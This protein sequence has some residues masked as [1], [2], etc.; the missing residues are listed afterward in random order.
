MATEFSLG[1]EIDIVCL[2]LL[3]LIMLNIWRS[4]DK[5]KMNYL[6]F[7]AMIGFLVFADA[8]LRFV[9]TDGCNNT[10]DTTINCNSSSKYVILWSCSQM[11]LMMLV[12][13]IIFAFLYWMSSNKN[14]T[15]ITKIML[16]T[17]PLLVMSY[18]VVT[19]SSNGYIKFLT[20]KGAFVHGKFYSALIYVVIFYSCLACLNIYNF[21]NQ[22]SD[23]IAEIMYSKFDKYTFYIACLLPFVSAPFSLYYDIPLVNIGYTVCLYSIMSLH[24]HMRISID[25]LT[26]LNNRN[27]LR[28]YLDNLLSMPDAE[29]SKTFMMFIDVNHFKSINDNFGHTEGDVVLMEISRLLKAVA[30][31]FNCFLCRYGGDE[32]ILI[33]KNANEERAAS[34]CKYIDKSVNSLKALTLAPYELSVSTGYV[35]F[36][37]RFSNAQQFIDAADKIMYETKRSAHRDFDALKSA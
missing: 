9:S 8:A 13:Y 25:D 18:F 31:S 24:Q 23:F 12:P 5:S 29:R 21:L 22:K 2:V 19:S 1:I 10:F 36:D 33:K 15:K 30:G 11:L 35:R 27:E 6:S 14:K 4:G 34:V 37:K 26:G 32:F 3:G 17:I 7:I 16:F 20:Y 28:T